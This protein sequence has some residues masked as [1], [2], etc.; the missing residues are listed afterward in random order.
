MEREQVGSVD[1]LSECHS[2]AD[3]LALAR[4]PD[5]AIETLLELSKSEYSFVWNALAINPSSTATVLERLLPKQHHS[6]WNR[7]EML[8]RIAEHPAA[9][10]DILGVVLEQTRD[11]LASGERPFA[12]ARALAHRPELTRRQILQLLESQGA[13]PRLRRGLRADLSFRGRD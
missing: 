7:N 3:F 10:A 6:V 2:P 5:V 12:A 1:P 13:S 9:T 11:L 4:D 8:L